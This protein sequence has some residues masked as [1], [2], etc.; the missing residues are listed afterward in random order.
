MDAEPFDALRRQR[1]REPAA[2]YSGS[3]V[4]SEGEDRV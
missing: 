3:G 2:D 1:H 4:A